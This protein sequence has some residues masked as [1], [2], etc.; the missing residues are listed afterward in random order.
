MCKI[1]VRNNHIDTRNKVEAL[2]NK[3]LSLNDLSLKLGVRIGNS[4]EQGS[5]KWF[6][7]C[8]DS[9]KHM[10]RI[11]KEYSK[12]FTRKRLD[13]DQEKIKEL[14]LIKQLPPYR[15]AKIMKCD[16]VTIFNR[17]RG[18]NVRIRG[19]SESHLLKTYTGIKK[20]KNTGFTP[21]KAYILGVLCGDGWI[22][23]KNNRIGLGCIDEDFVQEFQKNIKKVYG[24]PCN[25]RKYIPRN[26]KWSLQFQANL[27]SKLA[28][29]DIL[30]YG[31]F[32]CDE[33]R[34]PKE[35]ID[36]N[37]VKIIGNFLR[38][39]YDSEG[40][41]S[42]KWYHLKATTS[43]ELGFSDILYLLKKLKIHYITG[44]KKHRNPVYKLGYEVFITGSDSYKTFKKY[45]GF[46]IKRKQDRLLKLQNIRPQKRYTKEDFEKTVELNKEGISNY[47][48]S[49]RTG[50][51][52][53]TV[54]KWLGNEE[55]YSKLFKKKIK[56]TEF[57]KWSMLLKNHQ[58]NLNRRLQLLI[59][60]ESIIK[61]K[62]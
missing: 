16:H 33:W 14:Y 43:N 27:Y 3:G 52:R 48:I 42:S 45:I 20:I 9:K 4:L 32:N 29:E 23:L 1:R 5:I 49:R 13:L 30:S 31:K 15:I 38:G 62:N 25:V 2:L 58:K 17:L 54:S 34:V 53:N 60:V 21:E 24:V 26:Q 51:I 57:V 41:V 61:E 46:S 50:V 19:Y 8:I 44:F 18:M 36:S 28:C 22:S 11:H 12:I 56:S 40:H 6:K 59:Q 35:I 7:K 39:F 47:E 10:Q 55:H 37:D